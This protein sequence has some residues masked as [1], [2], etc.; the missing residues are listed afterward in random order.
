MA[1]LVQYFAIGDESHYLG[2]VVVFAGFPVVVAALS[3]C[4]CCCCCCGEVDGVAGIV[5]AQQGTVV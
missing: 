3:H 1:Y 2:S 5:V 4:C